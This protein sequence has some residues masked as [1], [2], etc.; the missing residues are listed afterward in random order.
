MSRQQITV[1]R[2]S[3]FS[4]KT[5]EMTLAVDPNDMAKLAAGYLIQDCFPYLSAE[6]REFIKSGITPQEWEDAFGEDDEEEDN[7]P[8]GDSMESHESFA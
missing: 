1:S 4:G 8:F 6:E 7:G 2:T 5:H 3:P